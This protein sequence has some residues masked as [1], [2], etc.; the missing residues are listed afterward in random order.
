MLAILNM[1]LHGFLPFLNPYRVPIFHKYCQFFT[2]VFISFP[3]GLQNTVLAI[4]ELI[5][6]PLLNPKTFIQQAYFLNTHYGPDT[7]SNAWIQTPGL[8]PQKAN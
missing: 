4:K 6:F 7:L 8:L 5:I 1:S 3:K 2:Y